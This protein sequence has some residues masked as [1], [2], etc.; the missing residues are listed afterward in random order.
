MPN[1]PLIFNSPFD[2]IDKNYFLKHYW[3]KRPCFFKKA[4]HSPPSYL[5][6]DELAGFSLLDDVES[7]LIKKSSNQQWSIEHGP[8]DESR[9]ETLTESHWTLLV[10]SIDTWAPQ[11]RELLS[12]FSFIPRWRFDDIMLS[13]ATDQG[14]VGPHA[15]NYDVFLVQGDGER[16]WR[17]G[18]KGVLSSN[19]SIIEGMCH[20]AEFDP[21]IDEVMQPGDMLY[22]PPET[23][24]WGISLGESMGY[25]VGYRSMQT[26]Q[27]L[28]LLTESLSNDVQYQQFFTD[29]YRKQINQSNHLEKEIVHWAQE[30]LVKLSKQPQLLQQLIGQQLSCSKLGQYEN[31]HEIKIDSLDEKTTIQLDQEVGVNWSLSNNKILLNVEGESYFFEV[32]TLKTI[33]K[34]CNYLPVSIKGFNF[35]SN[36]I[37][38]PETLAN[39]LNKGHIKLTN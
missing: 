11:T 13:F 36:D 30:Q 27:L 39:L 34:F 28:A 33:E 3:Q 23:P 32:N 7:R 17:V 29:E 37:D 2:S 31:N 5:S 24:H 16:R 6:A 4:F 20:Q 25:S 18:S 35:S 15:D 19:Q 9:F 1:I 38:F 10:Q 22:I 8:F 21:I 26:H 12:H 14:G